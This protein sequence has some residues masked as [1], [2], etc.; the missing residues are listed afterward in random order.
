MVGFFD[1]DDLVEAL[2]AFSSF[3]FVFEMTVFTLTLLTT[4]F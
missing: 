4:F 3:V 2:F 1:L